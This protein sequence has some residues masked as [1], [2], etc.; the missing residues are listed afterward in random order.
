MAMILVVGAMTDPPSVIGHKDGR[1][2]YVPDQ[3]IQGLV[4]GEASVATANGN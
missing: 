3:V 4:V 1:M 2:G